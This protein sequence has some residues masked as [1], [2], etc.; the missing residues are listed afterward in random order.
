MKAR[1]A[2]WKGRGSKLEDDTA[3]LV[4]VSRAGITWVARARANHSL[5]HMFA[6]MCDIF[7]GRECYVARGIADDVWGDDSALD[8]CPC[9]IC[10][11]LRK[12]AR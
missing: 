1:I 11:T 12:G 7:D 5:A 3:M 10:S 8:P 2:S 6:A 4:G 9:P